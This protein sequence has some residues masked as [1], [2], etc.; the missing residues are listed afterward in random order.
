MY[1]PHQLR[2]TPFGTGRRPAQEEEPSMYT[3]E[4]RVHAE[5]DV[6]RIGTRADAD[7]ERLAEEDFDSAE[8]RRRSAYRLT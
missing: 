3:E 5:T 7:T 4:L 6:E 8:E 1:R 2:R